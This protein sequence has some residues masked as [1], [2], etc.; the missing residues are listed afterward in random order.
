MD[1]KGNDGMGWENVRRDVEN[2]EKRE[3]EIFKKEKN[4][5]RGKNG[6]V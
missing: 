1:G 5:G 3:V 2:V 6:N 4:R